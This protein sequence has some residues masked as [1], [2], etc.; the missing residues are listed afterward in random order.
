[1]HKRLI[2]LACARANLDPG[3]M[4]GDARLIELPCTG[5]VS[6]PLLLW[7]LAGNADGVLVLG[8][9]QHTCRFD[10]AEDPA[11]RRV[12][13]CQALLDLVGLGSG[14]LQF[15]EPAAGRD[16]PRA[17]VQAFVDQLQLLDPPAL[18][19]AAPIQLLEREGLDTALALLGWIADQLRPDGSTWLRAAGLPVAHPDGPTL[20]AGD[21]PLLALLDDG[22]LRPTDL[23]H[24]LDAAI[25]V[26]ERL[27]VHGAGIT[28][29]PPSA[30][31]FTLDP[32]GA[33][34]VQ[35]LDD[36]IRARGQRLPRPERPA[37]VACDAS[38][39]RQVALVRTLGHEPV[40]VGPDPLPPRFNQP[41]G[42]RRLADDRL[43]RA[44]AAG[45]ATL[46]VESPAALARWSLMTRDGTWR[47]S[48]VRPVLGL[49][50]AQLSCSSTEVAP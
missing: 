49:E 27:D 5:R 26:L 20:V 14:R 3:S 46:L 24:Q 44:R 9:H 13:R 19:E 21:L 28:L 39:P 8:R 16:G 31:C 2:V 15:V 43:E 4:P 47:S 45:A 29:D 25:G 30:G 23:V 36:L 10:G 32:G 35:P 22:L 40:D 33:D 12:L 1:M 37:R 11:R 42:A 34:G 6:L 48:L 50:L 41:P 18:R 38:Q 17:A 7:G